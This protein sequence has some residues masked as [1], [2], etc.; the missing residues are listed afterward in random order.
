MKLIA[1]IEDPAVIKLILAHLEN[2][3]SAGQYPEHPP[4]GPPQLTLPGSMG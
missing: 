2:H 4:R 3:L 1:G